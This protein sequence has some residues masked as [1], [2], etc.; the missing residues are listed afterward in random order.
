M[1]TCNKNVKYEG[2]ADKTTAATR[3]IVRSNN[4]PAEAAPDGGQHDNQ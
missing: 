2:T 3:N 1:L 4:V